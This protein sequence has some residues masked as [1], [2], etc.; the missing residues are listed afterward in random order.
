MSRT[1]ERSRFSLLWQVWAASRLLLLVVLMVVVTQ[2]P[3]RF[4]DALSNWDVQHYL[5]VARSGYADPKEMAFFP[6]LPAILRL[7]GLVGV[8]MWLGGA[9]VSVLCSAAAAIALYRLAGQYQLWGLAPGS[10]RRRSSL[11]REGAH[12]AGL[13]A[14]ALWLVAPTAV[15]TA[16]AYTEAPFCA[17]A[18]WAWER[19]RRGRWLEASLLATLACTFRISGLFLVGALLVLA[20]VGDGGSLHSRAGSERGDPGLPDRMEDRLRNAAWLLVP[21]AALL[22]WTWYL[23]G[24]TGSWTAWFDAQ[25]EGWGR[26][27]HT[28][29]ESWEATWRAAQPESWPDRPRVAWVFLAEVVTMGIGLLTTVVCL[30]RRRWASAAWV[31]VMLVALG[32]SVWWMSISR[33]GLLW[34]PTF[35]LVGEVVAWADRGRGSRL[36]VLTRGLVAL[37]FAGCVLAD[38]VWAWLYFR[39]DWAS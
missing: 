21:A 14:A 7:F 36:A 24:L 12:Q 18:F 20:I 5:T 13:S 10:G 38:I 37:L 16:I 26:G 6:G 31:G 27:L 35:L 11:G 17:A 32:T 33:A 34:F 29:R 39:G 4:V 22:V 25:K 9:L 3:R 8:P 15:F 19:A 1:Q 28:P 2:E 23:H 30:L